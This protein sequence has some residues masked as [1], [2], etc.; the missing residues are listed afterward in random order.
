MELKRGEWKI[1]IFS[2]FGCCKDS[3]RE[4]NVNFR[5][6]RLEVRVSACQTATWPHT[7]ACWPGTDGKDKWACSNGGMTTGRGKSKCSE[8]YLPQ[9]HFLHPKFHLGRRGDQ[10]AGSWLCYGTA[11][12]G[13]YCIVMV[14][15]DLCGTDVVGL[16]MCVY[17]MPWHGRNI[18]L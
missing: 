12:V 3:K 14:L 9:C 13:E 2:K 11:A 6:D 17:S 18:K 15:L 7:G 5:G 4:K 16:W 8:W 10:L 1:E